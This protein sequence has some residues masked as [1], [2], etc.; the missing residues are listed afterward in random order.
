MSL[1]FYLR[2]YF[3]LIA[4]KIFVFSKIKSLLKNKF[5]KSCAFFCY[6]YRL[7]FCEDVYEVYFEKHFLSI[8]SVVSVWFLGNYKQ[9]TWPIFGQKSCLR[10]SK[11]RLH[12][13]V[14][15]V[16]SY[17]TIVLSTFCLILNKFKKKKH[18]IFQ[19]LL[20]ASG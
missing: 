12:Q 17:A 7:R 4:K 3:S 5:Q 14:F 13:N 2:I 15:L 19:T 18:L 20:D 10:F 6:S 9:Q 8:N 11:N 1:S 16:K